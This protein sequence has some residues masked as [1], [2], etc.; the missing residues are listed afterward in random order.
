VA[1][2]LV[3]PGGW[4][5]LAY[6][7]YAA[8]LVPVQGRAWW[9]LLTHPATRLYGFE[10]ALFHAAFLAVVNGWDTV[11]PQT[12]FVL[13]WIY[14]RARVLWDVHVERPREEARLP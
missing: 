14:R 4:P 11:L 5:L 10:P 9:R 3:R 1:L 13:T 12:L 7:A 2:G 6:V 8:L